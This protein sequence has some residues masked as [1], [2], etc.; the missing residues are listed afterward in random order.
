MRSEDKG[1]VIV[2]EW[3]QRWNR[4]GVKW[5]GQRWNGMRCEMVGSEV[6]WNEV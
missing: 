3:G 5:W 6:E 2:L 4:I 1:V